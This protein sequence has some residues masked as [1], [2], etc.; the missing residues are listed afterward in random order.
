MLHVGRPKHHWMAPERWGTTRRYREELK[1]TTAKAEVY[2][3][4]F[5]IA[6]LLIPIHVMFDSHGA[7]NQ[8]WG[9][10]HM[11]THRNY[12]RLEE[13]RTN[14]GA[15]IVELICASMHHNKQN[16]PTLT[17]FTSKIKAWKT[18]PKGHNNTVP[19]NKK[20]KCA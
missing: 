19:C 2:G 13:H 3:L 9:R 15:E 4:A 1:W 11:A 14:A 7:L 17:E 10:H 8:G 16:R 5:N 20:Q 6:G 18:A 12:Y